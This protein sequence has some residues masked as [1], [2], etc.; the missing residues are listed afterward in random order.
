MGPVSVYRVGAVRADPVHLFGAE[1]RE[2]DL[3]HAAWLGWLPLTLVEFAGPGVALAGDTWLTAPSGRSKGSGHAVAGDVVTAHDAAGELLARRECWLD[4]YTTRLGG[5][6]PDIR[7]W[8][9]SVAVSVADDL[10][11]QVARLRGAHE[12]WVECVGLADQESEFLDGC[13]YG[14]SG[15]SPVRQRSARAVRDLQ[16]EQLRLHRLLEAVV[17]I[18][19]FDAAAVSGEPWCVGR[20]A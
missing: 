18:G 12:A 14:W 7:L 5:V 4:A 15:D 6:S 13:Q 10:A 20:L 8:A 9:S 1:A 17:R 16:D 2:S 11:A 3:R 19:V